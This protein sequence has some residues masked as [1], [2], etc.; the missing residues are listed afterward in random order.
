MESIPDS[1]LEAPVSH[2]AAPFLTLMLEYTWPCACDSFLHLF[3]QKYLFECQLCGR[4]CARL[5]CDMCHSEARV[6]IVEVNIFPLSHLL[7]LPRAAAV[8][9]SGMVLGTRNLFEQMG[10]NKHSGSKEGDPQLC[11]LFGGR[12]VGALRRLENALSFLTLTICSHIFL[13]VLTCQCCPSSTPHEGGGYIYL[14]LSAGCAYCLAL[15]LVHK[16]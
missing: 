9:A 4:H 3:R 6:V 15:Y 7:R 10:S 11:L 1:V 5:C 13:C 14:F 8:F 16:H 12:G 2:H